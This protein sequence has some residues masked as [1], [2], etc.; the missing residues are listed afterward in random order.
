M[1]ETLLSYLLTPTVAI[2]VAQNATAQTDRGEPIDDAA[3]RAAASNGGE[4]LTHGRDYSETHFS[5]LKQMNTYNVAQLGLTHVGPTQALGAMEATLL[6]RDAVPYATLSYDS[7][8]ACDLRT[9]ER[10]WE[11]DAKVPYEIQQRACCGV[12]NRGVAL[13]QVRVYVGPLD[14]RLVALDQKTGKVDWA[15]Q[16]TPKDEWYTSTGAPRHQREGHHRE[17]RRRM[18]CKLQSGS[19]LFLLKAAI[20]RV[21]GQQTRLRNLE[22]ALFATHPVYIPG[23]ESSGGFRVAC[24]S[25]MTA[26]N[27][28]FRGAV[29]YNAETGDKLWK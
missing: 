13:Y 21:L 3:L 26:G 7:V 17:R 10:L 12:V 22:I 20:D 2:F 16:T 11:W 19:S 29:A 5:P 9:N 25:L 23:Q 8:F 24:D 18:C 1:T 4:R 28:V 15:V 14:G 27:S 6:V